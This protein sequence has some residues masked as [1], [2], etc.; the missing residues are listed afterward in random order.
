MSSRYPLPADFVPDLMSN[1]IEVINSHKAVPEAEHLDW[2][3]REALHSKV[4][5][6]KVQAALC[7]GLIEYDKGLSN[8]TR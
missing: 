3:K 5:A 7:L 4:A 8:E 6:V 2:L 1:M